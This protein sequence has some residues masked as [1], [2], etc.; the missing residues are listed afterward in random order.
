MP[1][2]FK[3]FPQYLGIDSK[4]LVGGTVSYYE[5]DAD[6]LL[7][8]PMTIYTDPSKTVPYPDT[9]LTINS[10]GT[11][12]NAVYLDYPYGVI[13]KD[14]NGD[15]VKTVGWIDIK[16]SATI[17]DGAT[18]EN[19][20]ELRTLSSAE[21]GDIV[22]VKGYYE[23]GDQGGGEFVWDATSSFTDNGGTVVALSPPSTGRWIRQVDDYLTPQM[24]GASTTDFSVDS[25]NAFTRLRIEAGGGSLQRTV[26]VPSGQYQIGGSFGLIGDF[27]L[28]MG[29]S[30]TFFTN[31]TPATFYVV[32]IAP[33]S[34]RCNQE[35]QMVDFAKV[36]LVMAPS[37]YDEVHLQWFGPKTY[38]N[39]SVIDWACDNTN[40]ENPFVVTTSWDVDEIAGV[41]VSGGTSTFIFR[42]SGKF[43]MGINSAGSMYKIIPETDEPCVTG[44]IRDWNGTARDYDSR[45]FFS[46][47]SDNGDILSDVYGFITSR[48][49]NDAMITWSEGG[50]SSSSGSVGDDHMERVT[51]DF[52][53]GIISWSSQFA[54]SKML[55]TSRLCFDRNMSGYI[56]MYQ[57]MDIRNFG[58]VPQ[59][60][61]TDSTIWN[62]NAN[63]FIKA[64]ESLNASYTIGAKPSTNISLTGGGCEYAFLSTLYLSFAAISVIPLVLKDMR[65]IGATGFTTAPE[66]FI[67]TDLPIVFK[68]SNILFSTGSGGVSGYPV[69]T[70]TNSLELYRTNITGFSGVTA[71]SALTARPLKRMYDCDIDGCNIECENPTDV[72]MERNTINGRLTFKATTNWISDRVKVMYNHFISPASYIGGIYTDTTFLARGG[73]TNCVVDKNTYEGTTPEIRTTT[74]SGYANFTLSNNSNG[75]SAQGYDNFIFINSVSGNLDPSGGSITYDADFKHVNISDGGAEYGDINCLTGCRCTLY[76]RYDA[77][78][79]FGSDRSATWQIRART[80]NNDDIVVTQIYYDLSVNSWDQTYST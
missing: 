42:K 75:N 57:D 39:S 70:S 58:C 6:G 27:D 23:A 22:F 33:K 10:L 64:V 80:N 14:I 9:T 45:C 43:N 13:V 36:R 38:G 50:Y 69:I 73:H 35:S 8:T 40:D 4:F 32:T 26:Y 21:D 77:G 54:I 53:G 55:P 52:Q 31:D 68:N 2:A 72:M 7:T 51:H 71:H 28:E 78:S 24:F 76:N 20:A 61:N 56:K 66:G 60:N 65:I 41:S 11:T 62:N 67:D 63:A 5:A 1:I 18:V 74:Y 12:D 46:T 19:I 48:G 37:S 25:S 49:G 17:G 47:T 29:T 44:Y 79:G 59:G 30:V 3:E 15:T 16:D 34:L